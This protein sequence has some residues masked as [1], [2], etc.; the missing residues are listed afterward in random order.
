MVIK[1]S[2]EFIEVSHLLLFLGDQEMVD[3]VPVLQMTMLS[4]VEH[5]V[6]WRSALNL[7]IPIRE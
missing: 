2:L 4:F 7:L 3:K 6:S 1:S 5:I